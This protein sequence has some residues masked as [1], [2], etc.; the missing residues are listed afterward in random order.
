MKL[1]SIVFLI[2][3]A[4]AQPAFE[5]ASLKPANPSN[6]GVRGGCHG[7]DSVYAGANERASAPPLGRCVISDGRLSHMIGT[8]FR[9]GSMSYLKGGP[10]WVATGDFRYTVDAKA[11]D[12]TKTTEEQL[13]QMLQALLIERFNLKFHRESREMPGYTLVVAK[14]G[15]KLQAA[16]GE[17]AEFSFGASGKPVPGQP[18]CLTAKKQTTSMLGNVLTQIGKGPT[19]DRT[20]LTGEYDFKL[21]WN[22]TDGPSLFSALQ[23][24]LGLKFEPQK[25]PVSF[26]IVD[27]AQKPTE[28]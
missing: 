7:I 27:S 9:L 12:P 20:G 2:G 19:V 28:N 8:A 15:P 21:C 18:T 14:N 3:V 16:K 13:L 5:V 26:F 6:S 11:E 1:L 4:Q 10:E 23:E 17:D 24:Q 25:V 22:D